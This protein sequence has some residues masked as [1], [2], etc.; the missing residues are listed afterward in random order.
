MGSVLLWRALARQRHGSGDLM[1]NG[2]T[3]A[4]AIQKRNVAVAIF[5]S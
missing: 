1:R 4:K 5:G 2:D 3:S